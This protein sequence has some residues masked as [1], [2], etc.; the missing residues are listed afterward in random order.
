MSD[1]YDPYEIPM[2]RLL[3]F[4]CE[5]PHVA[6]NVLSAMDFLT[7]VEILEMVTQE[8]TLPAT[9]VSDVEEDLTPF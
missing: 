3:R 4:V 8:I 9:S 7:P 1:S 6:E 2:G 5:N